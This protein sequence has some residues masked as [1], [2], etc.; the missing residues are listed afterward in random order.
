MNDRQ[1]MKISL[2]SGIVV[3]FIIV[4]FLFCGTGSGQDLPEHERGTVKCF[5]FWAETGLPV[6]GILA[7]IEG[8]TDL[9]DEYGFISFIVPSGSHVLV[10]SRETAEL[11]RIPFSVVGRE[12]TEIIVTLGLRGTVADLMIENPRQLVDAPDTVPENVQHGFLSGQISQIE[13]NYGIPSCRIFFRGLERE[14]QTDNEGTFLIELPVGEYTISV[15]HPDYVTRTVEG[16]TISEGQ[17]TEITIELAPSSF[18][19]EEFTVKA[20]RIEGGLSELLEERRLST[21]V[22]DIIGAEQITK[23]GDSD[24]ASALK[25]VTGLTV[26]DGK[27]VYVRGMGERYSSSVLN[28]ASLPSPEPERRV[29]PLDMFPVQVL[30]SMEIQK[31]YSPD[32]P[33]EFGGGIVKIRSKGIPSG[34]VFSVSQSTGY[35]VGT[36]GEKGLTYDGGELDWLGF[37][38]GTRDMPAIV[39]N[40]EQIRPWSPNGGGYTKAELDAFGR[41]FTNIWE[42]DEFTVPPNLGFSATYGN[43]LAVGNNNNAGYLAAFTYSNEYDSTEKEYN[44]YGIIDDE[45]VIKD[46]YT[47]DITDREIHLGGIFDLG[48]EC[49]QDHSLKLTSLLLRISDDQARQYDGFAGDQGDYIKVTSLRWIEQMLWVEQLS[50]NHLLPFLFDTSLDWNYT[51]SQAHRTEPDRR[52]VKYEWDENLAAYRLSTLSD[53]NHRIFSELEGQ[54]HDFHFHMSTPYSLWK[55]LTAQLKTGFNVMFKDRTMQTRRFYYNRGSNIGI[56]TLVLDPEEIFAPENIGEGYMEFRES[57]L[58]TDH[59]EAEQLLFGIYVMTDLTVTERLD[60]SGG[61]RLERSRQ[62][63]LTYNI[64]STTAD[65]I[66]A[67]LD[68]TDVLPAATVTWRMTDF[69]QLRFGYSKTLS[70][71]D[72]RELSPATYNDVVGGREIKGN[73]ELKR[74]M[75]INYDLRWEWYP[76][77]LENFSCGLFYKDF[78]A[79]IEHTINGGTNQQQSYANANGAVNY[80]IELEFRKNFGFVAAPLHDFFLAGNLAFIKS[81]VRLDETAGDETSKNRPL[82]GQSPYVLNFTVGYD[83]PDSKTALSLLFNTFGER[84]ANTGYSGLPDVYEQ[85]FRRLDFVF[86]QN[87]LKHI[88]LKFKAQNILNERVEFTQKDKITT[89]YNPGTSYSLS[90]SWSL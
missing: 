84:I 68:N 76:T 75:I 59:Y 58:N 65:Q 33:G 47:F 61:F 43:R 45:L 13:E 55:G 52:D 14:T 5:L 46:S 51:F 81:M 88:G 78:I 77:I 62:T 90:L 36:T 80:G 2:P 26:V 87:L 20:V 48:F 70:R 83:N 53:G 8:S 63:V 41:S 9:S 6:S 86:S 50:G 60:I 32:M 25:R 71:P 12:T 23:S 29:V 28:N 56:E 21:N 7:T 35:G 54:T 19:L 79:P 64:F 10:L 74:A 3:L 57:T 69:Q 40:A 85:P 15:I 17:T 11:A 31:T 16:I 18:E 38:D 27:Y 22:T 34:K 67:R 44:K 72:F 30:D 49:G 42:V 24:A 4:T 89:A 82:Q 39:R 73:P 1:L 66:T 37:D